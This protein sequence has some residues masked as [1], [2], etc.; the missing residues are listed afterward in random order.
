MDMFR[1][2]FFWFI[3]GLCALT[4]LGTFAAWGADDPEHPDG[5]SLRQGSVYF[6][7]G[8]RSRVH[9]GGGLGGGK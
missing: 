8:Y 4:T 7:D 1:H 2:P 6:F 5:V 9:L 3:A